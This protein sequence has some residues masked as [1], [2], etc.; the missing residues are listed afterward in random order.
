M[1]TI[2]VL[3]LLA[4]QCF[5]A[6]PKLVL[7]AEA[8]LKG[9]FGAELD[10]AGNLYF[11]EMTPRRF[12]KI[13]PQGVVTTL[14]TNLNGPH[15]LALAPDGA[16]YIADTWDNRVQ[17][18]DPGTGAF[19]IVVGT[20]EKG[21]SGDGGPAA[22]AKFGGIYCA[23]LD[24]NAENLYLADLD[25]RR[26]RAVNLKSGIVKT[27]AGNGQKGV[28]SDGAVAVEAPLVDPRAVI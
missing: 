20:G 8:G 15:N 19:T 11:V 4:V 16:I 2:T 7:V 5:G 27:V 9:P 12:R 28:P 10:R 18:F 3:C 6:E 14:H 24:P 21:F 26:I 1:R 25:N 13:D 17:K 23:S 22:K